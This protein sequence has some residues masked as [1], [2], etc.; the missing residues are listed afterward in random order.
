MEYGRF[1]RLVIG[2]TAVLV[3]LAL[4]TS[5]A[6]GI[7]DPAEV[8][9]Q[10]AIVAV[11]AVAV[12]WGRKAGTAAALAACL[13]YLVLRL[14]LVAAGLSPHALLLIVSRFSGYCLVGIVGGEIF[15]RMK[16]L[17]ANAR[18]TGTIDDWSQVY[19][20]RYTARS[21]G[22]AIE[23]HNRYQEPFSVIVVCL[24]SALVAVERPAKLRAAVRTIASTLRD[25][26]RLVDDVARLDDGRF[27]VML[28]HT[29][30]KAAPLVAGRLVEVVCRTLGF[31]EGSI[32]T[33][34]MSA[35]EDPAA[36]EEFALSIA[37][38]QDEPAT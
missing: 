34:C 2:G 13:I 1:E 29:P 21:L 18:D 16:Y 4:A 27:V 26:V 23:R 22:Q 20:Q 14:P 19:N 10:L 31:D 17:F 25:D 36:L 6:S 15:G 9:G 32:T 38:P 30:G 28:P 3:L 37:Y 24:E 12:H 5:L 11:M 35:H 8:F 7:G 33:T